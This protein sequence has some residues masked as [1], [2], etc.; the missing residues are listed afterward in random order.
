[1]D[2]IVDSELEL[3]ER[4]H[5]MRLRG[6]HLGFVPTMGALHAGHLSLVEA[7]KARCRHVV[8]SIFINPM[9]FAAHEDLDQYPRKLEQDTKLLR[10]AG[11]DL[12]Y[13]PTADKMY[14]KGFNTSI[15]VAGVSEGL[16][17]AVRPHHFTGVATVV[18][19]LLNQ[20]LPDAAFFGEKDYQ[21]LK[22]IERM[23]ADLSIPV[24]II[25]VSTSRE[26]D[27][28]ARSSRNQY[29]SEQERAIAPVLSRTLVQAAK[30]ITAGDDVSAALSSAQEQ[31]VAAGFS[32][33]DYLEL[34][35]AHTLEPLIRYKA[36]ARL[37]AAAYLGKTRLIDNIAVE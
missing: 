34:R 3:R 22:V 1:M 6:D 16:C 19:K 28:L 13:L 17:G 20:V 30:R 18:A 33:V 35:H 36:P 27:G 29:L 31:I 4:V 5:T 9:Q 14:P 2:I 23:V 10:E 25:P 15:T 21:Q 11:V 24:Q 7:A 26:A 8:V 32:R 37:L 12:I